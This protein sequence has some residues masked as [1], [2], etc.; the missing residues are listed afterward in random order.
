[1]LRPLNT[2]VF[3][4]LFPLLHNQV[5]EF[6]TSMRRLPYYRDNN[7]FSLTWQQ[8]RRCQLQPWPRHLRLIIFEKKAEVTNGQHHVTTLV[9]SLS[10]NLALFCF[11]WYSRLAITGSVLIEKL[12]EK[13]I[14]D[15]VR[16]IFKLQGKM[17]SSA[18]VAIFSVRAMVVNLSNQSRNYSST[19]FQCSM[20]CE[21]AEIPCPIGRQSKQ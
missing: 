10:H 6:G 3:A 13:V 9:R 5:K 20:T 12:T 1:M 16:G 8:S 14:S 15:C 21:E 17:L 19:L 2:R 4:K 11:V 7:P 18:A